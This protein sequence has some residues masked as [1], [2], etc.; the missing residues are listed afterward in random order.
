MPKIKPF[1]ALRF[2]LKLVSLKNVVAPPYDVISKKYQTELYNRDKF[3]I[4]RLILG[5]EVDRYSS[6]ANYLKNWKQ[7]EILIKD[8]KEGFYLLVQTFKSLDGKL[9]KRKGIIALCKIEEFEN[10]IILPHEKTLSKP[11]EDRLKLL[12][13]T[14]TNLD[15]IFGL[16][17]DES[18]LAEKIYEKYL[19]QKPILEVTFENVLNQIWKIKNENDINSLTELLKSK[20]VLIA[21]GHHRYETSLDYRNSQRGINANYN[22]EEIYNYVVMFFTNM[23]DE[24]LVIF[25]THRVVHSLPDF[26]WQKLQNSIALYFDIIDFPSLQELEVNLQKNF[27]HTFGIIVGSENPYKLLKIKNL[28]LLNS[29]NSLNLPKELFE[30]DVTILHTVILDKLMGISVAAQEKKIYIRYIQKIE[31]C[32]KEV[33]SNEA[34]IAFLMNSTKIDD[35]KN[36][37]QKGF[38]MPQKSTYFYPKLIS[39]LLLNEH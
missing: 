25:P 6:S 29:F 34:Q 5:N 24:G 17:S 21:D 38:T 35:V 1:K 31:E 8:E 18:L 3:N 28:A 13:S 14:K 15:Q 33:T 4:V 30:L 23:N 11:K 19:S 12:N 22:G 36:I 2:N 10:K 26:N 27:K 37:S 9:V 16:Y 32:E 39:G 20:Q 7:E